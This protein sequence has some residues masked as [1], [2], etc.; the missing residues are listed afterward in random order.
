VLQSASRA[1]RAAAAFP[2]DYAALSAEVRD[3]IIEYRRELRDA[4]RSL[5]SE[6]AVRK[7]FIDEL[8]A[9]IA[10][11]L[12]GCWEPLE[13]AIHALST[14]AKAICDT[15]DK[16]ECGSA[17]AAVVLDVL[18]GLAS[19]SSP[20]LGQSCHRQ[21]ACTF[22]MCASVYTP[23]F[24]ATLGSLTA[25]VLH[26][27]RASLAVRE[28]P[29]ATAGS[30]G[31]FPFTV[32][33]D[34]I[35]VVCLLKLCTV[36]PHTSA[37]NSKETAQNLCSD[38]RNHVSAALTGG[39]ASTLEEHSTIVLA[40]AI[41]SAAAHSAEFTHDALAM[42]L[43]L[44]HAGNEGGSAVALHAAA[45]IVAASGALQQEAVSAALASAWQRLSENHLEATALGRFLSVIAEHAPANALDP[46]AQLLA[47]LFE[48]RREA[49]APLL[50][51]ATSL[52]HRAGREQA[53]LAL[54]AEL[55]AG[56]S[57]LA[58]A[59][60]DCQG[61]ASARILL[62]LDSEVRLPMD[63]TES[64][65][66]SPGMV[67]P[68]DRALIEAW[69]KFIHEAGK[70]TPAVLTSGPG[71]SGLALAYRAA[72]SL[73]AA[74]SQDPPTRSLTLLAQDWKS[75]ALLC[76]QVR[77]V[78]EGLALADKPWAFGAVVLRAVM[79]ALLGQ[80]PADALGVL[81]PAARA[82]FQHGPALGEAWAREAV[83]G[84]DFPSSTMKQESKERAVKEF[85]STHGDAQKFK[86][87]LKKFC[88]GKKKGA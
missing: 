54:V 71:S 37:F 31:A 87:A 41:G 74:P 25:R 16:D 79:K 61:Q 43:S 75:S 56:L 66:G 47:R 58:W 55:V 39:A 65:T 19:D 10:S 48:N 34:H 32:K 77:I 3:E 18:H 57:S 28:R 27:A 69:A 40:Q 68:S 72:A 53:C 22:L 1:L 38:L 7:A 45:E 35:G 83:S 85:V 51:A 88:G 4:L 15:A 50:G 82:V 76:D 36:C 14:P 44:L 52:V 6:S 86:Q 63:M 26:L 78:L 21:L 73:L 62:V 80:M 20:V 29:P 11:R 84:E 23:I 42:C 8:R 5:T 49:R 12:H 59:E 67:S 81:V 64:A 60:L 30:D 46:L 70:S 2:A 24:R 13:E 9:D 17:T 33:Q